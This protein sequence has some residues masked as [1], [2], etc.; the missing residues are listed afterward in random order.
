[1]RAVRIEPVTATLLRNALLLDPEAESPSNGALL[2]EAGRVVGVF[3]AGELLPPAGVE[4]DLAGRGLAPGFID[5]HFHGELIFPDLAELPRV[6]DSTAS[7]LLAA[8]TTGFLATTVA[9]EAERLSEFTASMTALMTASMTRVSPVGASCL[10]IHLEGPWISPGASGAQPTEGIRDFDP[11]EAE[12][13]FESAPDTISMV[14]LA[15]ERPRTRELLGMLRERG[16]VAAL[17]HSNANA[18]EIDAA[19]KCGMTH[20]THLFNAMSGLHHRSLGVTGCALGDDRL[21]CDLI[22]DGAHVHPAVVRTAARAKRDRLLL[23]SDRIN[24]PAGPGASDSFGSGRVVDD[25]EA[26]RLGDGTLA[27]STLTLDRAVRN[28]QSFGAFSLLEAIAAVTIR[29]A[30]LLGLENERGSLRPGAR[31]DFAI[32]DESGHVSET[33]LAGSPVYRAASS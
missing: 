7:S 9:W 27:G 18:A 14:T 3:P 6:M 29:P 31:A 19:A 13:L 28:A 32:L 16:I 30:R 17:G 33:W 24:L 2:V 22:C 20:V 1:V 21:T 10:G 11:R 8:G 25:G 5:L 4:V 23:I 12:K 26:L 15:P